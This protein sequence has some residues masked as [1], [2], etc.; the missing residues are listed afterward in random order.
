MKKYCQ[1]DVSGCRR[2]ALLSPFPCTEECGSIRPQLTHDC[3]DLCIKRCECGQSS[4]HQPLVTSHSSTQ[5]KNVPEI[6]PTRNVSDSQRQRVRQLLLSHRESLLQSDLE[7]DTPLYVGE[8]L[9]SGMPLTLIDSVVDHCH[10][11]HTI[12]DLEELCAI[13]NYSRDIMDVTDTVL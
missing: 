2:T 12:T 7:S 6:R 10:L 5:V 11:I 4:L 9:A 1:L 8:D 3:C 13:W